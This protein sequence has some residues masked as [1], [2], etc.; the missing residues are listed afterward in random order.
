MNKKYITKF[1][2][3]FVAIPMMAIG[4]PLTGITPIAPQAVVLSQNSVDQSSAITAQEAAIHKDHVAKL[5]AYLASY[6]SPLAGYG[7]KFVTEAE[8]NDIDWRLLV[9]ISGLEST[10]GKNPCQKVNNSFLGYG[11][12]RMSFSSVDDAIEKVSASLGGNNKNTA[13]H[14]DGKTTA[15][16]LRKY[17]SVIPSYPKQAMKL[18]KAIDDEEII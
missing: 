8:K 10:F 12:C 14:Y 17:N 18:M 4:A 7:E 9:A 16:I 15:Q 1:L 6:N 2:Q 13:H 3:S 11:S 5:D